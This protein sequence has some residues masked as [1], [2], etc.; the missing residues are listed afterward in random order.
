MRKRFIQQPDL[1]VIPIGEVKMPTRSRDELPP[2]LL[3]LQTIFA[4]PQYNERIFCILDKAVNTGKST[5]GR[6][7]MDLW[8][9]IVLAVVRMTLG[10]NY[11]RL[12][13][14]ANYDSLVRGVMGVEQSNFREGKKY[15][16][17]TLKEN[18]GMLDEQTIDAIGE[19]VLAAGYGNRKK[20]TASKLR[21]KPTLTY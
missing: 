9:I 4:T 5:N 15:G 7:G 21:S 2:V 19:V 11:D 14:I 6:T 3:A 18:I 13:H 8:E 20:N 12:H 10:A 16:L 17:T 1:G